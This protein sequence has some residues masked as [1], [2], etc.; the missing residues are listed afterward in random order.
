MED[1]E[2]SWQKLSIILI[3]MFYNMNNHLK[4]KSH[5]VF[6]SCKGSFISKEEICP[7]PLSWP[8]FSSSEQ[9]NQK[10]ASARAFRVFVPPEGCQV[11]YYPPGKGGV[12]R[13]VSSWLQFE[14]SPPDVTKSCTN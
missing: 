13:G 10:A 5:R 12:N 7:L 8:C 11:F 9:T 3:V 4:S 6:I 14:T 1:L 2:G